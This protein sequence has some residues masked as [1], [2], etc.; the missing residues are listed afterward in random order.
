MTGMTH[1]PRAHPRE[2]LVLGIILVVIGVGAFLMN[3]YPD[4]GSWIV[5][6]I[7]L[8]LL[9]LFAVT[10]E[11][12]ALVPGGIMTGLGAGIVAADQLAVEG[13]ATGGVIVAGLG[14]GFLSIW[15]ISGLFHLAEHH[16]WPLI[17]GG[18][19]TAIGASLLV[20]GPA[21]DLLRFWPLILVAI[22]V[23]AIA[24]AVVARD[25]P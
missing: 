3:I 23:V 25:E 12:G 21:V 16:P 4:A 5:L 13:E 2:P 20:G 15:V 11:F 6:L 8:G 17:P 22:G 14:L 9:G 19:L 18:I 10:R 1:A 7:G 24:R